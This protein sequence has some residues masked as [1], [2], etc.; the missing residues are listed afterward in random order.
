MATSDA[1]WYAG[2][3]IGF[4]IVVVVV[5]VVAA[6]LT[7]VQR[8]GEDAQRAVR[9]LRDATLATQPLWRVA[10]VNNR[11]KDVLDALRSARARLERRRA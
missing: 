8:L 7:L 6:I 9:G 10:A 5:V 1:G 3:G 2:L 11:A 4:A